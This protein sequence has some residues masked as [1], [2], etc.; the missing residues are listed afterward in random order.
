LDKHLPAGRGAGFG[1]VLAREVGRRTSSAE[2]FKASERRSI[3]RFKVGDTA[4]HYVGEIQ[5]VEGLRRGEGVCTFR[6]R[7]LE[8]SPR[9]KIPD[10]A[11]SVG[12][13][14]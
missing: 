3:P 8:R 14:T 1:E 4:Y 6:C 5:L 11:L 10:T 7:L 13:R 12:R 9:G 2:A